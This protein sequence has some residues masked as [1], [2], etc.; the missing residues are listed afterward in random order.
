MSANDY[1][2]NL[3]KDKNIKI[4]SFDEFLSLINLTE[5]DHKK[6]EMPT[7]PHKENK[8]RVSYSKNKEQNTIGNYLRAQGIDLSKLF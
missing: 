2:L 1:I 3:F 8:K 4:L 5:S 7:I 6:I